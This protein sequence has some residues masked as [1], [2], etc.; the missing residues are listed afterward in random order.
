MIRT[1]QAQV[2]AGQNRLGL[3]MIVASLIVIALICISL[4]RHLQTTREADMRRQGTTLTRT[5]SGLEFRQLVPDG[6]RPSILESIFRSQNDPAFLYAAITRI[7]G[8]P[9][10]D[11]SAPGVTIPAMTAEPERTGWLSERLVESV[12]GRRISEF[13]A[14]LY[15]D[16][17]VVAYLRTG[18]ERPGFGLAREQIPFFAT[19]ALF[20]FLLT[21]LFYL[22]LRREI[23]PLREANDKISTVLENPEFRSV[24]LTATGDLADFMARFNQFVDASRERIE[25]LEGQCTKL[26]TTKKLISYGKA[27]VENVLEA[28]PEAVLI[29]DETGTISYANKRVEIL[30]GVPHETVVNEPPESWCTDEQMLSFLRRHS[31]NASTMLLDDTLRL[32]AMNESGRNL[33]LKAYPLFSPAV[34]SAI[35]GTLVVLRDVTRETIAHRSQGEF[36]A[37]VAHELKTPLNTIAI[38]SE[39]LQSDQGNETAFRVEAANIVHDEVERLAG[40]I[41]N[42]LSITKIEMGDLTIDRQRVRLSELLVD[43]FESVTRSSG[44]KQLRF[45]IDVAP[46]LPQVMADKELLRIAINNLLTNAIK[47][48]DDGDEVRLSAERSGSS[49]RISVSDTGIGISEPDQVAIFDRFFRSEDGAVRKRSGHGLGLSLANDI[50]NLHN[51]TLRVESQPGEG[52]TFTIELIQVDDVLRQAI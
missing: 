15:R 49:V 4:F 18:Y 19:L 48:S 33:S 11:V 14:P 20:V 44:T 34:S 43:A 37:H 22:L 41:G 24:E 23:R 5:L 12:A 10:V 35:H 46:D 38:Y 40:L 50:V 9:L 7:D 28:I 21:P 6:S 42:L 26:L 36:V 29:L 30:L 8:R 39:A 31:T 17:A 52:S 2:S 13:Y 3:T 1:E 32:R 47:Y 25:H 45:E 27:R 16:D 51:G